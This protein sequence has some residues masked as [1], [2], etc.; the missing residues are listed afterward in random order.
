MTAAQHTSRDL[1]DVIARHRELLVR[2]LERHWPGC[3]AHH[4]RNHKTRKMEMVWST[5]LPPQVQSDIRAFICGWDSAM[6]AALRIVVNADC[7]PPNAPRAQP[8]GRRQSAARE[9][10]ESLFSGGGDDES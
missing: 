6:E 2:E 4:K 1:F 10:A 9:R 5:L 3:G 7:S 8:C